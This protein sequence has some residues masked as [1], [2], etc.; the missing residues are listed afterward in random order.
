[1]VHP[2]HIHKGSNPIKGTTRKL[3]IQSP[4]LH[5]VY[6]DDDDDDEHEAIDKSHASSQSL[7][8]MAP[9]IYTANKF[10][11]KKRTTSIY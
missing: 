3:Y 8:K 5:S 9:Q 2:L 6:N 10:P 11:F 4:L 1:M 7:S